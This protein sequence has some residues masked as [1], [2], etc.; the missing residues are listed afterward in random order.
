MKKI[1]TMTI[2]L[3]ARTM[4]LIKA[5]GR[6]ITRFDVYDAL[7]VLGLACL[8]WGCWMAWKPAA[9]IACGTVMLVV[10]LYGVVRKSR[11]GDVK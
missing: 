9:P 6:F 8:W 4:S 2:A 5:T 3:I 7:S 11:S 1:I 10:G